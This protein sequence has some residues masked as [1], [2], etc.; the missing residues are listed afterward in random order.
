MVYLYSVLCCLFL[1]PYLGWQGGQILGKRGKRLLWGLLG[2][3][4]VLYAIAF[5][6]HRQIQADWMSHLM[7]ASIY[8]FFSTMYA[9]AVVVVLQV[10][11]F[12]DKRSERRWFADGSPMRKRRVRLIGLTL[13]LLVF[14]GTMAVGHYNVRYPRAVY[15]KLV[16]ERLVQPGQ[17]PQKR[18]RLVFFSDLHIGEAMTPDYVQ[19]AVDLINAQEADLILCGGD[20]IDHRYVYAYEE[21]V[22]QIMRQLR[23][24]QGV[25]FVLGNHEY[26]DDLEKSIAYPELIG[27]KLLRDS[28]VYPADSLIALIGRDDHCNWYREKITDLVPK[29]RVEGRPS[30]LF[31]HTPASLDSLTM[32]P[33]DLMLCGHTHGGQ[34]FPG[35]LITWWKYGISS[36]IR[37]EGQQQACVTAGIG[38]AGATYR[39]GTRSEIQVYDLYW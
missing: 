31:E 25:Y 15:Q 13:T 24:P 22:I 9:T 26:R 33:V 16:I 10:L 38:S 37:Q 27:A 29:A 36:G 6:T 11:N 20:Y 28:I 30:I 17:E 4:F 7:N 23:A 1:F 8:I 14:F 12:L 19:R 3:I 35:Q 5:F 32:V 34:L 18:M 21:R 39:F 2:V